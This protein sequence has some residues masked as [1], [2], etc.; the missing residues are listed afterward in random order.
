MERTGWSSWIIC[1]MDCLRSVALAATRVDE[2]RVF[3]GLRRPFDVGPAAPYAAQASGYGA[4][5]AEK[6][7]SD[8]DENTLHSS[9][10]A[11]R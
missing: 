11:K 5:S 7:A 4:R 6:R 1:V 2:C 9:S 8:A 10:D 3:S